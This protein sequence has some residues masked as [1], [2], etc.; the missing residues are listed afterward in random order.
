MTIARSVEV[1]GF[2][3]WGWADSK[4]PEKIDCIPAPFHASVTQGTE[5]WFGKSIKTLRGVVDQPDHELN[6]F[7]VLLSPRHE[8]WDGNVNVSLK[9][10]GRE[11]AGF[12]EISLV[13]FE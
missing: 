1:K 6:G 12:G 8:R 5:T 2:Y 10:E 4:H 11:L 13:S 9:G 7:E 3:G